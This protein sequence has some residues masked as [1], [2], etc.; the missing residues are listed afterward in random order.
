M[1]FEI[2]TKD[3][4][5]TIKVDPEKLRENVKSERESKSGSFKNYLHSLTEKA[6]ARKKV[7]PDLLER[8][9]EQEAERAKTEA[10]A[11]AEAE[12]AENISKAEAYGKDETR[13]ALKRTLRGDSS[14]DHQEAKKNIEIL[15]EKYGEGAKRKAL[16]NLVSDLLSK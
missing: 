9:K 5:R 15:K 3:F 7:I 16:K 1:S 8:A 6:E 4:K 12:A 2:E 14:G 11:K 13:E 10:I